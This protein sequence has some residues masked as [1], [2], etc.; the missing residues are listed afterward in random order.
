MD[1]QKFD[2]VHIMMLLLFMLLV[3]NSLTIS[4][5]KAYATPRNLIAGKENYTNQTN[6][7]IPE[8]ILYL[9]QN[10][11][12]AKKILMKYNTTLANRIDIIETMLLEGNTE[13]AFSQYMRFIENEQSL[14]NKIKDLNIEDYEKLL[15]LLPKNLE[16]YLYSQ[17]NTGNYMRI[18][19]TKL[20]PQDLTF[21]EN[22]PSLNISKN[23]F[24]PATGSIS[25]FYPTIEDLNNNTLLYAILIS[26]SIL[27]VYL[28]YY[29]RDK[30]FIYITRLR[31][32]R[33]ISRLIKR[34]QYTS[35]S[36]EDEIIYIYY[37]FID[38]MEEMGIKKD[39]HETPLEFLD[40]IKDIKIAKPG[41]QITL[42]FEKVRYGLKK[43]TDNEIKLAREN[44]FKIEGENVR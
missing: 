34:T 22:I 26:L 35:S 39:D 40:K 38:S 42:L 43:P 21:I 6:I 32:N 2:V 11:E 29:Y 14:L 3:L 33:K 20:T 5:N 30:I 13:K 1:I 18:F 12:E 9:L 28:A 36:L 44:I 16:K 10:L 25:L 15:Q 27:S 7:E 23:F 4:I 41:L 37:S 8:N 24:K 19:H 17:G 31:V